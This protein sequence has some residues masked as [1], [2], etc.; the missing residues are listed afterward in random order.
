MGIL[1]PESHMFFNQGIT[2]HEPDVVG[3]IITHLSLKAGLK[4][5]GKKGR[6][7]IHSEMNQ[8]HMRDTFLPLHWKN[9][10][11]DQRKQTLEFHMFL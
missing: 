1:H 9:M 6:D 7:E 3:S 2:R 8:L 10:L 11:Y 4:R 5:W